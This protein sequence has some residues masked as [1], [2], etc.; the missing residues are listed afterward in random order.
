MTLEAI[1][2]AARLE[3]EEAESE[4]TDE[5]TE[6]ESTEEEDVTETE[7]HAA[8]VA[9]A[10]H[11]I[12]VDARDK[13]LTAEER[14]H[15][16]ALKKAYG[17]SFADRV[18]CGICDG[19]GYVEQSP[20]LLT[21]LIAAG[22]AARA[23]LGESGTQYQLAPFAQICSVCDGY[24][25]VATGARTEH[26]ATVPCRAC[27]AQ[28]WIDLEEEARKERLGIVPSNGASGLTFPVFHTDSGTQ[29]VSAD[30]NVQPEGWRGSQSAGSDLWG[31]WPGHSRYGIDPATGGW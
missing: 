5:S 16:N 19:E 15:G 21:E 8:K 10:E 9:A 4:D 14:R 25:I 30:F 1:A 12:D 18:R 2:E 7:D 24:G 6:E 31:R 22:D 27:S 20:E 23:A 28:G 13:A 17:E 26:T 11:A 3:A 29:S